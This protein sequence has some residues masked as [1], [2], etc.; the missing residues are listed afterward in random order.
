M[1]FEAV[2]SD[3]LEPLTRRLTRIVGD[4]ET[5]EDLRQEA[6][7]R[8]WRSA[9]RDGG[10]E[11]LGAWL[12][13]TATN[14]ALDELRRRRRR[15]VVP[16]GDEPVAVSAA[17]EDA[18]AAREALAALTAHERLVL[19]LRFE[20][21]LSLR[22]L[23]DLL[24]ISEEAARKRVS[25]ARGAFAA[26]HRRVRADDGRPT[27]L[28]VLGRDDPAAYR[29]WLE[30]A[31]ARAR[32]VDGG[33]AALDLAGAD[34]LV[35]SGCATDVHPAV[36][37]ERPG[38]HVNELRLH[39]DLRDLAVLRAALAADL[40]IVGVCRGQQLLNVLFGG[41]LHQ[42][43]PEAGYDGVGHREPHPVD[44]ESDSVTRRMIGRRPAVVSVHHQAV[45]EVGR[46]LRVTSRAP[47]GLVEALEVPGRR[48][49]LGVQWHPERAGE[50]DPAAAGL[51]EGLV[52][53][54]A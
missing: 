34:A 24:G 16:L 20:A 36:Y 22:E 44:T 37:R 38:P 46:G 1:T 31:G 5:A 51:A 12:H 42:H 41:T 32:L 30:D 40:P 49:A 19:L 13:R 29:R 8:A 2:L 4:R 33:V 35:I 45:R 23:G 18:G 9:P 11:R 48:F 14:L 54:A 7:I 15:P 10:P 28:V 6:L 17:G 47:D 53:A 27:V 3:Q 25:R 43:L 52:E 39:R 26:A 21:G 50:G